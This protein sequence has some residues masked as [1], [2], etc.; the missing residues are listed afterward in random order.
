MRSMV[1]GAIAK[2]PP[3][4]AGGRRHLS[5]PATPKQGGSFSFSYTA[6]ACQTRRG[7]LKLL[8]S[9]VALEFARRMC[10]IN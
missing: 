7:S 8:D 3:S 6:P 4:P 10:F 1:E 9:R 2:T 5:I